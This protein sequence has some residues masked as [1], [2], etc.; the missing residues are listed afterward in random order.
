M[1]YSIKAGDTDVSV[2]GT[3][4]EFVSSTDPQSVSLNFTADVS[5]VKYAGTH[6]ETLTFG[7]SVQ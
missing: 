5:N 3:V 6:T 2:G 7:V 4:A 1:S